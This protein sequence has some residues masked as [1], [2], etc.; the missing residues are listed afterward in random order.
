MIQVSLL[1]LV[2]KI[3]LTAVFLKSL[4]NQVRTVFT[5]CQRFLDHTTLSRFK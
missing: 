5:T 2:H 3:V 1:G 4:D